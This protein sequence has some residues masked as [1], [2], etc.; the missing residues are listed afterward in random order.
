MKRKRKTTDTGP[1]IHLEQINAEKVWNLFPSVYVPDVV[2]AEIEFQPTEG[3]KTIKDKRFKV[4][5]TNKK[6]LGISKRLFDGYDMGRNDS[7]VLAHSIHNESEILFTD[8]LELRNIAKIEGVKPVGSAGILYLAFL[9]ELITY[10]D[11]FR[12]LD[13]LVTQSSLF[14][15]RDIIENVKHAANEDMKK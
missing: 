7:I 1:L 10:D 6:I 2:I 9:D 14:I 12:Y 13:L 11:L 4:I 8:D 3:N 5:K 15:T